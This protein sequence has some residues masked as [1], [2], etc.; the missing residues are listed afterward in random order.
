MELNAKQKKLISFR[1]FLKKELGT[2]KSKKI[3]G[4]NKEG[5]RNQEKTEFEV[6][7]FAINNHIN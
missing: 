4:I 7:F 5:A 2:I 1:K 3:L 6:E